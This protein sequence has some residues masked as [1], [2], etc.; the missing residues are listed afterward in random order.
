[1]KLFF[2][3]SLSKLGVKEQKQNNK[4]KAK[5]NKT[6]QNKTKNKAIHSHCL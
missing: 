6:K 2:R 1:M 3:A 4:K 5:Q